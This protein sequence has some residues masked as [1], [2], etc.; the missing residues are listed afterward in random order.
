MEY[1]CTF[2]VLCYIPFP[3]YFLFFSYK[4]PSLMKEGSLLHQGKFLMYKTA[5]KSLPAKGLNI[6]MCWQGLGRLPFIIESHF[7]CGCYSSLT[8]KNSF[9]FSQT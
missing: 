8:H 1:I 2:A 9:T 5:Y 4:I 6:R 7:I 3:L